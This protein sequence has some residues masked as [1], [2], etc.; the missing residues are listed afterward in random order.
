MGSNSSQ[1]PAELS[2]EDI[3]F[4]SSKAKIDHDSVK[5]WYEKLKVRLIINFAFLFTQISFQAACPNGKISKA[6]TVS[7]LRSINSGK[8]EQI[9]KQAADIHKAF[10]SNNDGIVGMFPFL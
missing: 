4:I 2:E 7:F 9:E 3:E 8:E 1:T 5:I 6:D 10:D